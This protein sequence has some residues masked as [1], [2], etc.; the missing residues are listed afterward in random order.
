V[1]SASLIEI[2]LLLF[3]VTMVI[4]LLGRLIIKKVSISI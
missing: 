3:A 4:N 2:G 1:H